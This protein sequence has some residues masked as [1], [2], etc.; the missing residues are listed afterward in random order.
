MERTSFADWSCPC[1]LALEQM[2]DWWTML[3][4]REAFYGTRRFSDFQRHLGISKNILSR[5]LEK[6][7]RDGVLAR[8]PDPR[9]QR[10]H[11]YELTRKGQALFPTLIAMMQWAEEWVRDGAPTVR[12]VTRETGA[13]LAPVAV[14]DAD[15]REVGPRD[16]KALPG[17]GADETMRA[18]LA[19]L[20]AD[21]ARR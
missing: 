7:E 11:L 5:R 15:G 20:E 17:E 19:L 8:R 10:S 14:R 13:E 9:D 21:A 18:R 4:I 1:A 16:L 6:M 2:G 12:F 3:I